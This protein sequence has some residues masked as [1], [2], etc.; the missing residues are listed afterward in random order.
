[1]GRDE[2]VTE[3]LARGL[4]GFYLSVAREGE[5]EAGDA[6]VELSRDVRRFT[7]AEVAR[8]SVRPRSRGR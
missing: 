5:V 4:L 6:I 1:M 7:V 8:L 3:F 2:F